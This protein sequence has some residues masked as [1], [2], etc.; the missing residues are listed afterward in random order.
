MIERDDADGDVIFQRVRKILA[1][2]IRHAAGTTA[3]ALSETTRLWGR[4]IAL[5]SVDVLV[6]VCALEE[7]FTLTI[8]DGELSPRQVQTVGALVDFV[9][10]RLP[11]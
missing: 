7:E 11:P 9:R 4:G 3:V 8:D 1:E 6:L 10:K 5:D 2:H